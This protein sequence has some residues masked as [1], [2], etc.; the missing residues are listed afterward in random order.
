MDFKRL[1]CFIAVAEQQH[2]RRAAE[3]LNTSQPAVSQQI[4]ALEA[5]LGITLFERS[6]P[7]VRLTHA[8]A[9]YFAGVSGLVAELDRCA[10]RAREAH[11]GKRGI[12]TVGVNGAL[13]QRHFPALV[14]ALRRA[15]PDI[16]VVPTVLGNPQLLAALRAN[17]VELAFSSQDDSGGEFDGEPMWALPWRVILP[18]GHPL[19][20]QPEVRLADLHDDVLIFHPHLGPLGTHDEVLALCREQEFT[21]KAM[22]EVPNSYDL[23]TLIGFIACGYGVT[24]LPSPY[25]HAAQPTVAFKRIAGTKRALQF[26][27]RYR[28]D[29]LN[30]LVTNALQVARTISVD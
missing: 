26:S 19:A 8:G 12:L 18:A 13:M 21:P 1:R 17:R 2:F 22:H 3:L 23:Q 5:E 7:Q 20:V 6:R 9:E 4:A 29:R 27:A 25:E 16:A 30:P 11:E 10:G 14:L 15:F 28:K 24:M